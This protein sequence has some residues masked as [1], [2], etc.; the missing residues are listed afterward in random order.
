MELQSATFKCMGKYC[1]HK[2]VYSEMPS[3]QPWCPKCYAMPMELVAVKASAIPKKKAQ[4]R[5]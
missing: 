3:E 4:N 1:K 2:E 5:G